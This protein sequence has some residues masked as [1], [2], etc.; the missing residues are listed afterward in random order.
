M[1]AVL[2]PSAVYTL[3]LCINWAANCRALRFA[4]QEEPVSANTRCQ[5]EGVTWIHLCRGKGTDFTSIGV[6]QITVT[7]EQL[8]VHNK[9][10][11][12]LD[13]RAR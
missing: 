10:G 2:M 7:P 11:R 9:K 12:L 3:Y 4:L 1:T 6:L 5:K 13:S 8:S